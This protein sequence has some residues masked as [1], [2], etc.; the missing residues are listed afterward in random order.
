MLDTIT[1]ITEALTPEDYT[2]I[3]EQL[4]LRTGVQ[5]ATGEE[6]F[7]R[8]VATLASPNTG[9]QIRFTVE[10]SRWVKLPGM[11]GPYKVP[12]LKTFRVEG[13]IHK[14]MLGHNVYGGPK[15]PEDAIAWF[16]VMA[17]E[18]LSLPLP[19]L[20]K[21][22]VKRLDW[23]E[24]FDL[25]SLDNVRGWI[26]AKSLVVYP[27]R[28]VH[29]W[30]DVGFIADGTT[31]TLR[32][33]AKGPQF[34]SEG[35]YKSL[36]Q[37]ADA[38]YAYNVSKL[39]EKVLRCEVEIKPDVLEKL[40]D[41]G[42]ADT[43]TRQW[44]ERTMYEE[45]W[46]KFLRP[47]DSDSRMAHTAVEVEKRLRDTYGD[48][49]VTMLSLY[50]VWCTLAVRG[51]AWYR[52]QIHRST[53]YKQRKALE[54]ACISWE[55]TNVLTLDAPQSIQDFFPGLDAPERLTALLP[56]HERSTA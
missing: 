30:G 9:A 27:R 14:A 49:S 55:S 23:A 47:I 15:E 16:L 25:G 19:D 7:S 36:L 12:G 40:E 34:H 28:E 33:Y 1:L 8:Y 35:G 22:Y 51:E 31:T 39:A 6:K 45:Q 20:D 2:I 43:I 54:S 21:W 10:T 18:I 37:C 11:R 17:S 4:Q 53:W 32:A 13:S 50:M 56:L 42:R 44:L 5:M 46:K 52:R 41:K 29:F 38:E 26:R 24:S 3:Q 48:D